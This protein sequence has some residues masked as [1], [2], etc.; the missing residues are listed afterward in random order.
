MRHDYN[1]HRL[2]KH[3]RETTFP[4]YVGLIVM[5]I[6]IYD[7]QPNGYASMYTIVKLVYTSV[8]VT[9]RIDK[10]TCIY[11]KSILAEGI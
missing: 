9:R 8:W 11:G 5:I 3:S 10:V 2:G 1:E 7:I 4:N 6:P